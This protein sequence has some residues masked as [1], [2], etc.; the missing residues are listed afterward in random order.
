[1][2]SLDWYA[3]LMVVV[4]SWGA[5]SSSCR[6]LLHSACIP[7]CPLSPTSE[8]SNR[9]RNF[10]WSSRVSQKYCKSQ[11]EPRDTVHR[12]HTCLLTHRKMQPACLE[13][14]F[15]EEQACTWYLVLSLGCRSDHDDTSCMPS[16]SSRTANTLSRLGTLGGG[17]P[18]GSPRRRRPRGAH[19]CG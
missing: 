9:C 16:Y 13:H 19:S 12:Y 11:G 8:Q 15:R 3:W 14:K 2:N 17:A 6:S 10:I 1:M 18:A 4:C 5:R 7:N